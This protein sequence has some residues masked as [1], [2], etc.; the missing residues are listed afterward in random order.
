[1]TDAPRVYTISLARTASDDVPPYVEV[2][3]DDARI[4]EAPIAAEETFS[5][6]ALPP[7]V[8]RISVRVV[9]PFTRTLGQ[10]RVRIVRDSL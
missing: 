1:M 5:S 6:G 9:N 2:Y 3:V 7:G 4:G 10:R 8:H